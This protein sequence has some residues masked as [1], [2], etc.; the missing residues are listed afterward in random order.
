MLCFAKHA[1]D[2]FSGDVGTALQVHT[3]PL[4]ARPAAFEPLPPGLQR[5]DYRL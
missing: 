1:F 4:S 3:A 5:P 2:C